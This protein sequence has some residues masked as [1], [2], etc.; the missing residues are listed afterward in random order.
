MSDL[1]LYLVIAPLV[2]AALGAIGAYV[3][4]RIIDRQHPRAR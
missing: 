1:Q 3:F 4:I 2:L